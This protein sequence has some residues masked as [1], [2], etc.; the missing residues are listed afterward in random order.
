M[1]QSQGGYGLTHICKLERLER[2]PFPVDDARD[3]LEAFSY[4]VSFARRLW[5]APMLITGFDAQGKQVFDEWSARR[6]DSWQNT[7]TWFSTDS[8]GLVEAF[9]GFMRR[10]QNKNWQKVVQESIRWYVESKKQAGGVNGSIVLQQAALERLAWVFLVED[11]RS[12]ASKWVSQTPR[13]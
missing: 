7:Y 5:V 4:Y 12:R 9:P 1:L 3:Q 11:K 2:N 6:A 10:W 13:R 8:T